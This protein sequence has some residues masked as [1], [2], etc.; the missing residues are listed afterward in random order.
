MQAKPCCALEWFIHT[1]AAQNSVCCYLTSC[2]HQHSQRSAG[3]WALSSS[4]SPYSHHGHLKLFFS[5]TWSN[6]VATATPEAFA[7]KSLQVTTLKVSAIDSICNHI[8]AGPPQYFR[9]MWNATKTH[10]HTDTFSKTSLHTPHIHR[11][12]AWGLGLLQPSKRE[13]SPIPNTK[14][15]IINIIL[16]KHQSH[17]S[18]PQM[19]VGRKLF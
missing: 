7:P 19:C 14:V 9:Y 2:R 12:E 6:H 5:R 3:S 18:L 16:K 10:L 8:T 4:V 1:G 15:S 11:S 13:I 17:I